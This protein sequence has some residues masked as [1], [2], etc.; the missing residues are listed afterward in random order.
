MTDEACI[1]NVIC[2]TGEEKLLWNP[3]IPEEVAAAQKRFDEC[4]KKGYIACKVEKDGNLGI[5]ITKFDPKAKV[6]ILLS[7]FEGG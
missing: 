6:I 4:L 7:I 2:E 5:Q 1:L 3:E